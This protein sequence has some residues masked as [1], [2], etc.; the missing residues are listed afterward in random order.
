M[1]YNIIVSVSYFFL[2]S[3]VWVCYT[4]DKF[5]VNKEIYNEVFEKII[6]ILNPIAPHISEEIWNKLGHK[7]FIAKA[8][9]PSF[10]KSK[11]D[12]K[13]EISEEFVHETLSD[14]DR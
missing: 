1:I 10:D 4:T 9:W 11:I 13:A 6:L 5:E 12:L 2:Y 8:S 14:I 7:E 3:T